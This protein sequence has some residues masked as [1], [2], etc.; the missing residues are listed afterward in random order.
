MRLY[1]PSRKPE[2]TPPGF[3]AANCGSVYRDAL[4][5]LDKIKK[6]PRNQ[7]QKP[8]EQAELLVSES[9]LNAEEIKLFFSTV[10]AD[11]VEAATK[12]E[13]YFKKWLHCFEELPFM[14]CELGGDHGNVFA[15][16]FLAEF[17]DEIPQWTPETSK[18]LD[19]ALTACQAPFLSRFI[20]Q[21]KQARSK[22]TAK[23]C[24]CNND[25]FINCDTLGLLAELQ[26]K[27]LRRVQRGQPSTQ[28][29]KSV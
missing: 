12:F 14:V 23:K 24:P 27:E 17:R 26:T 2:P 15:L 1:P 11:M 19:D 20:T 21:L 8:Y 5:L 6:N 10:L 28:T 29:H 18:R 13:V 22:H 3:T 25:K 4:D 7:L 9:S 16:A